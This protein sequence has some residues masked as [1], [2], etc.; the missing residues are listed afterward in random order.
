MKL[1][2]QRTVAGR[3]VMTDMYQLALDLIGEGE[4]LA[5]ELRNLLAVSALLP[6]LLYAHYYLLLNRR[7]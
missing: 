2:P 3:Q 5:K 7:P 1:V 4:L 6:P